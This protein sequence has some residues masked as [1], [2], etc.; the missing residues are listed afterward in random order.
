M[1]KYPLS[2]R[3]QRTCRL[4]CLSRAFRRRAPAL[5]YDAKNMLQTAGWFSNK[6]LK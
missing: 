3:Q 4:D 1:K 2:L 5:F 6:M